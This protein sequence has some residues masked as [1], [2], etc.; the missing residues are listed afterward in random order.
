MGYSSSKAAE[1]MLTQSMAMDLDTD[2]IRV[3]AI[4]RGA[5]RPP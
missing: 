1:K 5:S 2:G 3:N 4:A